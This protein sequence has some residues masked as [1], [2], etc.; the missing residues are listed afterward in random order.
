MKLQKAS[1]TLFLFCFLAFIY[2]GAAV[3]VLKPRADTSYFENRPLAAA[4]VLSSSSLIDGSFFTAWETYLKDHAAARETLLK[5]GTMIDL[6]V[7]HRPVVNDIVPTN[8]LLLSY[9]DYKVVDSAKIEAAS[10]AMADSMKALYD[11]IKQDG[12]TFCFVAVPGQT[13]YDRQEYPAYLDNGGALTDTVVADFKQDMADRGVPFVDLGTVFDDLG[14]P[15]GYY[16]KTDHHFTF[17]GAFS[18]NQAIIRQIEHD[19]GKS[20]PQ[21]TSNDVSFETLPNPFLGSRARKLFNLI[22]SNEHA[23]IG[24]LKNPISFTRVNNG[25]AVPA[26]VYAPPASPDETVSYTVYMGGDI[27]ETVIDTERPALPNVL[28]VGDS[29]TNAIECLMYASFNEMRSLDLRHYTAMPLA[30]YIK[31]YKPDV[32][33]MIRDYSVLVTPGGNGTVF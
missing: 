11:M 30:D 26:T 17:E 5:V 4:P 2:I 20:L 23:I 14:H 12:G 6:S 8:G 31:Q 21:L 24:T 7:L 32:V 29:Y 9:N 25:V 15:A 13:D 28:I 33:I 1:N 27:A 22:D 16:S 18:A 10:A 19:T 3:T